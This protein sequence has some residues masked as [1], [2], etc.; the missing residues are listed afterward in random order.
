MEKLKE[1]HSK[2]MPLRLNDQLDMVAM[3]LL[4]TPGNDAE[5]RGEYKDVEKIKAR[6]KAGHQLSLTNQIAM[7]PTPQ[8]SDNRDRGSI[9]DPC[10]QRR[11]KIKKQ[12]PLQAI[13]QNGTKTGLKLQPAFVEWMMGYPLGWTDLNSQKQDTESK[14]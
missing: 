6:L 13:I 12:I 1:R 7:L 3:G 5:G 2:G 8:A 14:D 11:I 10:I 4:Q 9:N